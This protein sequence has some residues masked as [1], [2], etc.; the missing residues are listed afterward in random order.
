MTERAPIDFEPGAHR[1]GELRRAGISR[2]R[3][4]ASDIRRIGRGIVLHP[5]SELD[6]ATYVDR[7]LALGQAL[8]DEDFLSRRSAALIWG[9]PCPL[10]PGQ[11]IDVAS[12][13][14]RR[15]PRRVD[16]L[17]HRVKAGVLE[18]AL[19]SGL[20]VPS[21]ADVWCQLAAVLSPWDLVAAGDFLIS[22]KR[23]RGGGGARD[24]P[25]VLPDQLSAAVARH[26]RSAGSVV[27][28]R[29]LPLLRSPVD[30]PQESK[31]RLMIVRAGFPEPTVNCAVPVIGRVLHADLGYP[32]LKIAIEYEGAQH[33]VDPERVRHD[34]ERR[35]RMYEAGWRVLRVMA[36]DMHQPAEFLRRLASAIRDA[37]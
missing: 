1:V 34:A 21:P 35:E 5:E 36:K 19:V 28:R 33:F 12:F 25:L 7:C 9:I 11:R 37:S 16:V 13:S 26:T 17:G 24:D 10:P 22:G 15:A 20:R 32:R 27:R 4:E 3:L 23:I 18:W 14:P 2:N 30:S 31:L 6:P 8:R 29:V